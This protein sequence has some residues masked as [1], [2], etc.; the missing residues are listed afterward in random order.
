MS[1]ACLCWFFGSVADL[2]GARGSSAH[3]RTRGG[4]DSDSDADDSVFPTSQLPATGGHAA[5]Q[6]PA[7]AQVATDDVTT[8]GDDDVESDGAPERTAPTKVIGSLLHP[9]CGGIA[10]QQRIVTEAFYNTEL[11]A[12]SHI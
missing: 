9:K 5:P 8:W 11:I 7:T 2:V 10:N 3:R 1:R 6:R 4:G 12:R